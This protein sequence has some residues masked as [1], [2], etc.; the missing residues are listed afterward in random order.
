[1]E[2]ITYMEAIKSLAPNASFG[3][4]DNDLARI[5]WQDKSISQP[6]DADIEA[7]LV[8]LQS[9]YD[10]QE[11]ARERAEAY[12]ITGDQLDYIF[13]NGVAKWKTDMI[14]PVKAKYPKPS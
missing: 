12:P 11:Y 4:Y 9:A 13:H 10:A 3:I 14:E 8:R 7:E 6:S 1:M 2:K 5:D